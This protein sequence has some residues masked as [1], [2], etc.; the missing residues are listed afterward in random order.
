M[1]KEK[2]N[3]PETMSDKGIRANPPLRQKAEEEFFKMNTVKAIPKTEAGIMKLIQELEVHRIE[4]EMQND[5]LRKARETAVSAT[6]KFTTLY[7]F[8][9]VGYFTINRDGTLFELNFAGAN[10]IGVERSVLEDKNFGLFVTS[11]TRTTFKD[12]LQQIFITN[13]KQTCEVRLIKKEKPSIFVRLVGI[14]SDDKNQCLVA[15]NDISQEILTKQNLQASEVRY[16]RLFESAKDGILIIDAESGEIVDVNPYLINKI[17]YSYEELLG[18]ELWEIGIFRNIAASKEAFIEL[19]NKKYIRFE[20]MPLETKN[21]KQINVEFVSN[22]YLVDDKKVI[23]CNIRDITERKLVEGDLVKSEARLRELNASKDK[24]FSIISHDLKS[25][26]N[27]ILGYSD[28]LLEQIREKNYEEIQEYAEIIQKSSVLAL[29]LLVNLLEWSHSQSGRMKFNPEY[30]EFVTLIHEAMELSNHTA[31]QKSITILSELPLSVMIYVDKAMINTILRN[32]ISNA[33]KFTN[34]GGKIV[35]SAK[36]IKDELVVA[37]HDNGVGMTKEIIEKLFRIEEVYST[38]GTQNEE[39]SGL[40]LLLC[41][42]FILKHDGKIWVRS[43]PG[44]GSKF[45]FTLPILEHI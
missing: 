33:I 31:G 32:L 2:L 39:G 4:L 43:Q 28:I 6:D 41:K 44:I 21:G 23:Q 1:K 26:F 30:I 29:D 34:P 17:G 42:E 10:M 25:P 7:D 18:K 8:A 20:D 3:F 12:F 36:H 27:S 38:I 45:Y 16:R 35:I 5:E 11:D 40:G 19:Q 14:V 22:V 24:F 15:G 9:P 37:V 13:T